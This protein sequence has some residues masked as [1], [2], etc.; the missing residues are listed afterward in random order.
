M[1]S[2]AGLS[3][4]TYQ[5]TITINVDGALNAPVTVPVTLIADETFPAPE[6]GVS[7][8][9]VG[10]AG[11][12][13]AGSMDGA[14]GTAPTPDAGVADASIA[15]PEKKDSGCGCNLGAPSPR[16]YAW[17]LVVA[18]IGLRVSRRRRR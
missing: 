13:E 7:E 14:G 9:G 18:G 15:A 11:T 16:P 8:A 10:E 2:L 5:A 6:A 4:G 12:S 3:R 1:N 17:A